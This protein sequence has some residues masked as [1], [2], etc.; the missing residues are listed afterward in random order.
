MRVEVVFKGVRGRVE[1]R[2]VLLVRVRPILVLVVEPPLELER[3]PRER[4]I[5][6]LL[7][8]NHLLFLEPLHIFPLLT[9]PRVPEPKLLLV[10]VLVEPLLLLVTLTLTEMHIVHPHRTHMHAARR[11]RRRD[12]RARMRAPPHHRRVDRLQL[13]TASWRDIDV[14]RRG[15]RC[16]R[17]GRWGHNAGRE[18]GR[19][20][21]DDGHDGSLVVPPTLAARKRRVRPL[22]GDAFPPPP[23]SSRRRASGLVV[24]RCFGFRW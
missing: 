2:W 22:H 3:A 10:L 16:R 11:H 13:Y 15:Q 21:G 18:W 7:L 24:W 12:T 9:I 8:L 23:T 17:W 20:L 6:L 4:R 14:H 5:M 19:G 1:A